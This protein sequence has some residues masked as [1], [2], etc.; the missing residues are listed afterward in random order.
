LGIGSTTLGGGATP[1][2]GAADGVAVLACCVLWTWRR[3]RRTSCGYVTHDATIL[4][5]AEQARM[6]RELR[7]VPSS[8]AVKDVNV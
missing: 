4:E 3:V 8:V 6:V 1:E 7:G 2:S 5:D